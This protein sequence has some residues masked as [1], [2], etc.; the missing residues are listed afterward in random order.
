MIETI[1]SSVVS[2][3]IAAGI[4]TATT[5]FIE[6]R[7]ERK[8]EYEKLKKERKELFD[9]RPEL[10]IVDYKN[11]ITR[12]GYG[13]KQK[14]DIEVFL[15]HFNGVQIDNGRVL[16][17]YTPDDF[18]AKEWCCLIYSFENIGKTDIS[19]VDVISTYKKDT[20]LF[21]LK[22]TEAFMT[23]RALN[24]SELLDEKIRVG[25][26][27]TLKL[28]FHKDK[29]I[30]G[31]LSSL[32]TIGFRDVNGNCWQQPLFAPHEKIYDSHLVS[33]KQYISDCRPDDAIACFK[34]PWL[35]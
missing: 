29:I 10:K 13:L 21:S 12:I 3:L 11:Y 8:Q 16:A 31:M 7:K 2:A 22:S 27:F 18:N 5:L 23:A 34:E 20:A 26:K 1:I 35:W 9:N 24:Y 6:R 4:A 33:Y 17:N 19:V 15:A 28:C 14:C 30:T 25:E 32:L